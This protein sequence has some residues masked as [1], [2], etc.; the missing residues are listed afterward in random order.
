MV[1]SGNVKQIVKK[2]FVA[3]SREKKVW[4]SYTSSLKNI[5]NKEIYFTE[6]EIKNK[7]ILKLDLHGLSLEKANNSIKRFIDEA[8]SKQCKKLLIVTGKGSRSKIYNDPYRSEKMNILKYSVPWFIRNNEDLL[9]KIKK[10]SKANLKDGG[11]G[12]FYIFLK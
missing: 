6:K 7:K 2:K 12:A 10:I 8:L 5:Y 11:E 3:S 4:S 9:I 1:L